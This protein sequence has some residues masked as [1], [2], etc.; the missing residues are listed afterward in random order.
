MNRQKKRASTADSLSSSNSSS[1]ELSTE[2]AQ[3]TTMSAVMTTAPTQQKKFSSSSTEFDSNT[4]APVAI[5]LARATV[6]PPDAQ[7]RS[8]SGLSSVSRT[9]DDDSSKDEVITVHRLWER[10]LD[11]KKKVAGQHQEVQEW[12]QGFKRFATFTT[13]ERTNASRNREMIQTKE[14]K[15]LQGA[16]HKKPQSSQRATQPKNEMRR[17]HFKDQRHLRKSFATLQ[18]K[19]STATSLQKESASEEWRDVASEPKDTQKGKG[20]KRITVNGQRRQVPAWGKE[21][22]NQKCSKRNHHDE[23]AAG[24]H[25]SAHGYTSQGKRKE[26]KNL[27]LRRGGGPP[28]QVH[29]ENPGDDNETP[30]TQDTA[31]RSPGGGYRD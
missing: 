23:L 16:L 19:S 29:R 3:A 25:A 6:K 14:K 2:E 24:L 30:R 5:A 20:R 26:D 31:R 27:N 22:E 11:F 12:M 28:G 9:D 4:D 13:Q 15:S 18:K 7:S 8:T 10:F 17:R 21:E 1:F